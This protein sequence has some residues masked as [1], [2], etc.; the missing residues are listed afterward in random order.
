[1]L[2]VSLGLGQLKVRRQTQSTGLVAPLFYGGMNHRI[3][4]SL[5]LEGTSEGHLVQLTC[6]EQGHH[7]EGC[8]GPDPALTLILEDPS[9]AINFYERMRKLE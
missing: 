3:T 5:E 1:M 4:G 8:P 2:F 9:K 6:N 7:S